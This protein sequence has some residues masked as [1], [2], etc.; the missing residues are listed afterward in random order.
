MKHKDLTKELHQILWWNDL[1]DPEAEIPKRC[2]ITAYL[3]Y[4]LKSIKGWEEN[5]GPKTGRIK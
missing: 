1:H 2:R 5:K 3:E 4:V